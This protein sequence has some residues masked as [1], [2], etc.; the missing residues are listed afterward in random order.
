[1][2]AGDKAVASFVVFATA[3]CLLTQVTLLLWLLVAARPG[4]H[5][6]PEPGRRIRFLLTILV[7]LVA[8]SL[9]V[10]LVF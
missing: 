7:L 3:G 10:G 9:F 8:L 4:T 2:V 1:M 5:P 6:E